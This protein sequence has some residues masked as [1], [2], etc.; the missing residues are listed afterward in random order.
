[1][2]IVPSTNPSAN[3]GFAAQSAIRAITVR[4]GNSAMFVVTVKKAEIDQQL[5][6]QIHLQLNQHQLQVQHAQVLKPIMIAP[7]KLMLI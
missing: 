7:L 5:H 3:M 1:M 6:I 4:T 2:E